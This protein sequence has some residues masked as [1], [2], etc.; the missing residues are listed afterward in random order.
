MNR[1]INCW[2]YKKCG[3][4]KGGEN[5]GKFG[6]CSAAV[7]KKLDGVHEGTNAGRS[8]WVV[9]GTL[10]KGE[11]QGTFAQKFKSCTL[12]DFY[13]HVK[14]EERHNFVLSPILLSKLK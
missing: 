12:C 4:H 14:E 2:E 13:K 11:I 6:V 3:R 9:S 7:E 10:C 1:K 5:A 8:C